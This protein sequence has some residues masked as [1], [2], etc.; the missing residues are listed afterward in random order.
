MILGIDATNLRAGGGISYLAGVLRGA[1]PP[2]HGFSQVVVWAGRETLAMIEDR[3]WLVK[4]H[5]PHLDKVL[6]YRVWWQ[7]SR[8]S[9]SARE[10]DCDVLF[11]PGGSFDGDFRPFVAAS[12]N[13]L[14]FEWNELKRFGWSWMALKLMLLRKA[15]S[16]TFR[17]ADGLV[18]ASRYARD[19]VMRVVKPKTRRTV[20]IPNG[21]DRQFIRAPREQLPI[22]RYSA[23]NPFRILYVSII[24]VYKHHP[25]VAEAASRLRAGGFPVVLELVGPAYPPAMKRLQKTVDRVDPEGE[26]IRQRGKVLYPELLASYAEADLFVFA[27]SCENM[28]LILLEAMT[29]GLPIA[30]SDSGPMTE[31]LGDGG[32]YFNP[33]KPE[34][35]FQSLHAMITSPSLRSERSAI[36]FERAKAY[37]WTRC[38]RETLMFLSEVASAAEPQSPAN[39]SSL[40]S[41]V[42]FGLRAPDRIEGD[43]VKVAASRNA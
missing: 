12:H 17:N 43:R 13:L 15:Q 11:V 30:C 2:A 31:I 29:S 36:S 21:V 32:V 25:E 40:P 18:F 1:D 20:V 23:E 14:P 7:L 4:G 5:D 37:D 26:L 28:P 38:A 19:V 27:S 16:R 10:F 34:E 3:P 22:E 33:E 41:G 6:P 35:I 42:A 8:L 24:D 39:E 9:A